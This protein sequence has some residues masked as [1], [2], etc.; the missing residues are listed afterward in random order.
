MGR[1]FLEPL[2]AVDQGFSHADRRDLTA[3]ASTRKGF[4]IECQVP[5]ALGNV[6]KGLGCDVDHVRLRITGLGRRCPRLPRTPR[7]PGGDR[8]PVPGDGLMVHQCFRPKIIMQRESASGVLF[9]KHPV[10]VDKWAIWLNSD[11]GSF[12]IDRY[13]IYRGSS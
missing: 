9:S 10:R 7:P 8:R 1:D 3:A 5:A 6:V 13:R 2:G 12:I 4:G 11:A